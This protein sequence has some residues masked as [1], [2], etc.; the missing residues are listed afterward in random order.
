MATASNVVI[1]PPSDVRYQAITF[2][3]DGNYIYFMRHEKNETGLL[4]QVPALGGSSRKILSNVDSKITFA[5]DGKRFAFVRFDK[6]KGEYSLMVAQTDGSG[7]RRLAMRSNPDLFSIYGLAWSPN[8][9]VIACLDGSFTGGF[10]MRVIEVRVAD[11]VEKPITPRTWF[12]I[13]RVAWLKDGTGVLITVAEES[14]SPI[15]IWFVSYP[16]GQAQRVTNDSNDYRDLSL[17]ADSH[18][19]VSVQHSR[20]VTMW[21][22]PNADSNR[23]VQI[24]SGVGW[25]YGLAWT[26]DN[27]IVYSTM[28]SGKLDLWTMASD[29]TD[30]VQL[31]NDAGSNYHP[32]VSSDGKTIFFSSSRT[33][34]FSI[35]RMDVDGNNQKQLTDTGSDIHPFPT[36]DGRWVIFQRGGGG[37]GRP[38]LWKVPVDGGNAVQLTDANLSVPVVSPD[39]KMIACRY[40]DES[41][42]QKIAVISSQG[43]SPLKAFNIPIHPWQRI[44]WTK[45]GNAL[46]YVDVRAGIANIWSQPLDGSPARQVTDFRAD[47]IFS[48]DWSRDGKQLACER[49]VETNDVVLITDSN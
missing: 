29:G 10:H 48:Y 4:Y 40:L 33:G 46:T 41:N 12:G 13:T 6:G 45:D 8:G 25:T 16:E 27:R 39:G 32:A 11:G 24:T 7:E 3:N 34:P 36:P 2:S 15:Q 9:D 35:W 30:K 17:T 23:A 43:G 21:V 14:V 44:R 42:A 49:G 37:G 18:T 5:P 1:A 20:L 26:P 22:A 31:T 38:T 19:L 28:A 47:Q